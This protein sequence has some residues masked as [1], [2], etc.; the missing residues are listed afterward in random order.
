MDAASYGERWAPIYDEVHAERDPADAVALLA[1]LAGAGPALE[2]GVGSG[3]VAI[4]LA[5]SGVSVH[6]VDS[7]PAMV[8][9]MRAKPG[10][11]A[12]EVTMTSPSSRSPTPT[13]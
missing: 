12:I 7:S 9:R 5:A 6:G 3:R 13:R 11:D 1:A 4:P 8:E 10:G 2:L